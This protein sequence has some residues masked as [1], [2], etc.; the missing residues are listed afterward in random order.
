MKK[1][2]IIF[3]IILSAGIL[4]TKPAEAVLLFQEDFNTGS[5]QSK[6]PTIAKG[7]DNNW[8]G[9]RFQSGGDSISG[10]IS[11]S[12]GL[13]SADG[14]YG[15]FQ[16]DAGILLSIS[17]LGYEDVLLDF[18][19]RTYSVNSGDSFTA[20]Y[21]VGDITGFGSSRTVNLT[22]G[23]GNAANINN[24]TM[25]SLGRSG[26][27]VNEDLYL[28]SNESQV[29][30]AFWLNDGNGD[31]GAVDNIYINGSLIPLEITTTTATP[32]PATLLLFSTGICGAF[33]RRKL[34]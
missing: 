11:M 25:L 30:F 22:S 4:F 7:A 21:F 27:F 29:W 1:D 15:Y 14:R 16:D 23:S 19:W 13:S 10:D 18:D 9:A 24:W 2:L 32:E 3:A 6:V 8:Y 17:T 20:G 5:N 31:K 33:L 34:A 26:S 12:S 28:P